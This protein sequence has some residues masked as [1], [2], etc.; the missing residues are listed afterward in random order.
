MQA[1][2]NMIAT[3]EPLKNIDCVSLVD[4]IINQNAPD[5]PVS[6]TNRAR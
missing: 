3:E 4:I 1:L 5:T 2:H 6:T